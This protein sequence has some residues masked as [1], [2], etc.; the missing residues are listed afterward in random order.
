MTGTT[1]SYSWWLAAVIALCIWVPTHAQHFAYDDEPNEISWEHLSSCRHCAADF[2]QWVSKQPQAMRENLLK[3]A[4]S[5]PAANSPEKFT[6]ILIQGE[7]FQGDAWMVRDQKGRHCIVG[8]AGHNAAVA[9]YVLDVPKAG[10]YRLW[11]R[12]LNTP[13]RHN[14][15]RVRILPDRTPSLNIGGQNTTEGDLIDYRFGFMPLHRQGAQPDYPASQEGFIWDA[16]PTFVTLPAGKVV[17]EIS[18][19]IH[20][21]PY[22]TRPVDCMLLTE[23]PYDLPDKWTDLQNTN[24]PD[25]DPKNNQSLID[26]QTSAGKATSKDAMQQWSTRPAAVPLHKAPPALADAWQQWRRALIT[27]LAIDQPESDHEKYLA[28][29]VYF[30]EQWNLI[31][32]PSQV[33]TYVSELEQSQQQTA[34][35]QGKFLKWIEAE[36]FDVDS[37]W[38]VKQSLSASQ[39]NALLA[40][41]GDGHGKASTTIDI[42]SDGEYRLWTRLAQY[43]KYYA[44]INISV[45]QNGKVVDTYEYREAGAPG[46]GY[47]YVWRPMDVTLKAGPCKITIAQTIGQSPYA[48]RWVDCV[49]MTDIKAWTPQDMTKPVVDLKNIADNA[50][51]KFAW[52]GAADDSWNGFTLQAIP[53]DNDT[54]LTKESVR[55]TVPRGGV[56]SRVIHLTNLTDKP[57]TL[58][59]KTKASADSLQWRVIAFQQS[60]NYGWQP[61]TLL[62]RHSVTVPAH[63]SAHLWLTIDGRVL[64]E[65]SHQLQ[66]TLAGQTMTLVADVQGPDLSKAPTPYVGGWCS[67]VPTQAGWQMF[68]DIGLTMLHSAVIPKNEMDRMNIK[69]Q[70]KMFGHAKDADTVHR[71]V[72][73]MKAMGLDYKDWSWEIADE[74][75][76]NSYPAWVASAKVIREADPKVRIWCNPGEIQGSTPEAVTAMA[77][78]VDV[79][80]PYTNHF[81]NKKDEAYAKLLPTIGDIKL[82]YTTPCFN[83]M[84]PGSP[85]ELLSMGKRA[86]ELK[87]DGWDAFSLRNYYGYSNTAWDDVGAYNAA[88]A[89][90]MYPGAWR[91]S[92]ATRNLEAVRAAIQEWK[93]L[94]LEAK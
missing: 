19:T 5:L 38:Q 1:Q 36:T 58:T 21:G 53:T 45:E 76:A 26:I 88:Q 51:Q 94:T 33:K 61:T 48:Y 17:I 93:Q 82:Y 40:G 9:R 63:G 59:P 65:G 87:L 10:S 77:P 72:T 68:K 49:A 3:A 50:G 29:R 90:S 78:Y 57:D 20:E 34:A 86:F 35:W 2:T 16:A 37:G 81:G 75:N 14:T 25:S 6:S 47:T 24:S 56:V 13:G 31:G 46:T 7:A 11:L 85:L 83:E 91:Q 52:F 22:A 23:D 74:P 79:F 28:Q 8:P 44:H 42:P 67:P 55:I 54:I 39:G 4:A 64:K 73:A 60:K 84:A 43:R 80:C 92:I 62:R 70:V 27:R 15:T 12:W 69:L 71:N 41:Y 89:V 32:T 66:F 18:G 30:E